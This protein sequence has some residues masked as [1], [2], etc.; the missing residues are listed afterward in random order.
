[1][2]SEKIIAFNKYR[3]VDATKR[4]K[5]FSD[6]LQYNKYVE[7]RLTSLRAQRDEAAV[8]RYMSEL[9]VESIINLIE[10]AQKKEIDHRRALKSIRGHLAYLLGNSVDDKILVN[11]L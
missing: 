9:A 6:P 2:N 7:E 11:G 1:M 5:E 8:D 4:L 10:W 3:P